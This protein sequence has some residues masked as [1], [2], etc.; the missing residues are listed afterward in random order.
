MSLFGMSFLARNLSS[1]V[2]AHFQCELMPKAIFEYSVK[3]IKI[4]RCL[5]TATY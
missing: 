4:E 2:F 1:L 5:Q 3:T